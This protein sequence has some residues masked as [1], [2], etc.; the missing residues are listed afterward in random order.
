LFDRI[1]ITHVETLTLLLRM[2]G[3]RRML[4]RVLWRHVSD[5]PWVFTHRRSRRLA[6]GPAGITRLRWSMLERDIPLWLNARLVDLLTDERGR[7]VGANVSHEG[8]LITV[9]A[10]RGVVLAAGGFES[11]QAMREHYL[12]KPTSFEWSAAA[13]TNTGDAILA[14]ISIGAATRL[15]DG[16]FWTSTYS[17][18]DN[19]VA[20]LANID[21]TYAGNCVVNRRGLRIANESLNYTHFQLE[22][23]RKHTDADPQVP[24]WMIFD[25]RYRRRR[26][27]GPLSYG[28]VKPDWLL[29]KLYFS[30]G[31]LSK[32]DTIRELATRAGID[33]DGLERTVTAMNEYAL[34]GKDLEFGR[35]ES[36]HEMHFPDPEITGTPGL[37]PIAQPPF[38]A[39]RIEPGDFGTYGGLAIDADA[40][41][42]REDGEPIA[43]L[44]ALGLCAAAIAPTYPAPGLSLGPAMVFAWQAAKH[45]AAGGS[46]GEV[47]AEDVG[48][49]PADRERSSMSVGGNLQGHHRAVSDA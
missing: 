33:A 37:A 19:P 24:M 16:A 30:S 49:A 2:P 36:P 14:A 15:M 45:I 38:Y 48:G 7:V 47:A 12:P 5:V 10:R 43:G 28:H 32:A 4:A 9:H 11:N 6:C 26:F 40:R 44:Y 39:L 25:R 18:P 29:P 23:F 22:V 3:W 41:V 17:V 34:T 13:G 8:K 31:F 27:V 42:L 35:G 21:K 20:W 46:G 1:A